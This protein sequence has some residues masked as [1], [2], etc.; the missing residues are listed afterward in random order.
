[1]IGLDERIRKELEE[2]EKEEKDR[3][4]RAQLQ[5]AAASGRAGH[6]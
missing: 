2:E 5:Q 6:S 1:M 3:I 4:T